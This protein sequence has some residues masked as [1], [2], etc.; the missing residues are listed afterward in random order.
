MTKAES[1]EKIVQTEEITLEEKQNP[2][3]TSATLETRLTKENLLNSLDETKFSKGTSSIGAVQSS[4]EIDDVESLKD[5]EENLNDDKEVVADVLETEDEVSVADDLSLLSIVSNLTGGGNTQEDIVPA[6]LN[7]IHGFGDHQSKIGANKDCTLKGEQKSQ[8][9]EANDFNLGWINAPAPETFS[10]DGNWSDTTNGS[11]FQNSEVKSIVQEYEKEPK[12][13]STSAELWDSIAPA[14]VLTEEAQ[15]K[16]ENK[17]KDLEKLAQELRSSLSKATNIG[18]RMQGESE[19]AAP[20]QTE[21]EQSTET[22]EPVT[23]PTSTGKKNSSKGLHSSKNGKTKFLVRKTGKKVHKHE[24][25]QDHEMHGNLMVASKAEASYRTV[26]DVNEYN[27]LRESM[28]GSYTSRH[29]YLNPTRASTIR[30]SLRTTVAE[31]EE[32]KPNWNPSTI[33]DE[34]TFCPNKKKT[35]FETNCIDIL[36]TDLRQYQWKTPMSAFVDYE[37]IRK[38]K[39]KRDKRANAYRYDDNLKA[40]E[41]ELETLTSELSVLKR[42]KEAH[43]LDSTFHAFTATL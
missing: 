42:Q 15:V 32:D 21:Y 26:G 12:L 33:V 2:V 25:L 35:V 4:N 23:R 20:Q 29:T 11:R 30:A 9:S 6:V 14:G 27:S 17:A 36:D 1:A 40:M 31:P 7:I 43:K 38:Y 37:K 41:L 13:Y 28:N 39:E 24:T 18:P 19:D 16:I 8:K 34:R 10:E 22:V 5:V 3:D